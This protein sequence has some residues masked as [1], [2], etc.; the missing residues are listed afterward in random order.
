MRVRLSFH[1]D[2]EFHGDFGSEFLEFNGFTA[3]IKWSVCFV[4]VRKS[5]ITK[6]G[7]LSAFNRTRVAKP[8]SLRRFRVDPH[9]LE[10]FALQKAEVFI[11]RQQGHI[12]V[13]GR[14]RYPYIILP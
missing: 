6:R 3:R 2:G 10:K 12:C 9:H 5:R 4:A 8:Q 13:A 7:F 11:C 1:H 14:C